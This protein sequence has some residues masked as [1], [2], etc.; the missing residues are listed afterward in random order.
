MQEW[1]EAGEPPFPFPFAF[2]LGV[3]GAASCV[4]RSCWMSFRDRLAEQP[5]G[6]KGDAGVAFRG[7]AVDCTCWPSYSTGTEW[8]TDQRAATSMSSRRTFKRKSGCCAALGPAGFSRFSGLNA[9]ALPNRQPANRRASGRGVR[10]CASDLM[11]PIN[12]SAGGCGGEDEMAPIRRRHFRRPCP[13]ARQ[14]YHPMSP[15]STPF[16]WLDS[17]PWPDCGC[18]SGWAVGAAFTCMVAPN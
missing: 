16:F 13:R 12:K 14:A 10:R 2:A 4:S 3:G 11:L 7:A 17:A 15:M 9:A 18:F 6:Q 5:P 8:N 1:V